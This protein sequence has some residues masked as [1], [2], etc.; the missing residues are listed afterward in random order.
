MSEENPASATEVRAKPHPLLAGPLSRMGVP[1]RVGAVVVLSCIVG[2]TLYPEKPKDL[3]LKSVDFEIK[4][5]KEKKSSG[6]EKKDI[7]TF[8][9]LD[10]MK[11][12]KDHFLIDAEGCQYHHHK[13]EKKDDYICTACYNCTS[14]HIRS[15]SYLG[16][17]NLK[18]PETCLDKVDEAPNC[19][20]ICK[21]LMTSIEL[22][23]NKIDLAYCEKSFQS[24]TME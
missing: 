7:T 4:P 3:H 19:Y 11:H 24:N 20:R 14:P 15:G 17:L 21:P 16:V 9:M 6:K 10:Y 18:C 23:E 22:K 8:L 12:P 1:G 13:C 5:F 2:W